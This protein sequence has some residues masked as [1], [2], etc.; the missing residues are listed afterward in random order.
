[1]G[2]IFFCSPQK[3]LLDLGLFQLFDLSSIKNVLLDGL[4][5]KM[6]MEML[7]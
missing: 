4:C 7:R 6:E 1:M 2:N 3:K 5:K